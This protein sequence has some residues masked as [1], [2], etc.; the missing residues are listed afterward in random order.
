MGVYQ[1]QLFNAADRVIGVHSITF[2]EEEGRAYADWL[3]AEQMCDRAEVWTAERLVYKAQSSG[4]AL[5]ES[6]RARWPLALTSSTP[7]KFE[8]IAE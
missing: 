5:A 1:F 6:G 4:T 7:D 8:S 2:D 3:V